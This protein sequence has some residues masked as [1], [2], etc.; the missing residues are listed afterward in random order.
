MATRDMLG[1]A[2]RNAER[3]LR[4]LEEQ[5]ARSDRR[6]R[7]AVDYDEGRGLGIVALAAKYD[8]SQETV[9]TG[10]KQA[11]VYTPHRRTHVSDDTRETIKS[12]LSLGATIA[13]VAQASGISAATVRKIGIEAGVI[14]PR[15]RRTRSAEDFAELEK[16]DADLRSV[17]GASLLSLGTALQGWRK[18]Q[19]AQEAMSFQ[20]PE[21]DPAVEEVF[22]PEEEEQAIP[23][24][25]PLVGESAAALPEAVASDDEEDTPW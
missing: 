25:E 1:A 19:K 5:T 21:D 24:E 7:M 22:A 4:V 10:L 8:V 6:N 23:E 11:G 18:R 17:H 14:V 9:R 13:D 20:E 16:L 12:Q 15:G 3:A 2:K